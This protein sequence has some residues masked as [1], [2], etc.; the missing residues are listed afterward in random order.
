MKKARVRNALIF[1]GTSGLG[2]A[3]T[4]ALL[5]DGCEQVYITGR[6]PP[7]V[8]ELPESVR[9][10]YAER[11]KFIKL[12]LTRRDY[13]PL[14]EVPEVDALLFCAGAGRLGRFECSSEA[15]IA[16]LLKV[17]A[18]AGMRVIR[19][20][21]DRIE[22]DR[23]FYCGMIT[24]IAG[25]I[26]SP[27]FAVYAGAKAALCRFI[28]SV[29]AE[30][31]AR[32]RENR[33][34]NI[35]PGYIPGTDFYGTGNDID[36]LGQ[37]GGD[38]LARLYAREEL[39][40]PRYEEVYKGVLERY[41][42]DAAKFGIESYE[43]KNKD[44]GRGHGLRTMK[45][46]YMSGTFDLFHIGHLNMIK[47]A[48]SCCDY[49]VVGVHESGYRKGK[50]TYIPFEERCEILRSLELVDEVI[51]APAEDSDAYEKYRYD[52]LFVGSDY[53]GSERFNRYEELFKDTHTKIVYFPYTQGTSSTK[54]REALD[55]T[56]R[57]KK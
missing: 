48:K 49:L 53:K 54:L 4:I 34:L 5:R 37:L 17:N 52:F 38:I 50:P 8:G 39:F 21:Y 45:V 44:G 19:R 29:N 55:I 26:S 56:I 24:S 10:Q 43:Y 28:E 27:M 18:T 36:Q 25:L 13:S 3:L 30:L 42:A 33:I 46:G 23:P 41:R 31:A 51:T 35:A 22:G 14:D 20:Y 15:D 47:N 16:Y 6:T 9:E 1:G 32:G 57:D 12:D 11:V 40:I 7:L 2:L